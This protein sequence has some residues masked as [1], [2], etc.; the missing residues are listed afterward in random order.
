FGDFPRLAPARATGL[1]S[2]LGFPV[3][4]GDEVLAIFE[5]Y[6]IDKRRPNRTTLGAVD[7]LGRILGDIWVRKRSE[8]ALR[9]SE[10]RWR[11]VFETSTLGILLIDHD[12][13]IVA[14]NRALHAMLGYTDEELCSVSPFDLLAE[15]ERDVARSR[16]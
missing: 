15:E 2:A 12:L 10:E 6:S 7:Q 3:I 5:F 11:L 14:A 8:A 9:A 4:L 1:T 16:L 13:K